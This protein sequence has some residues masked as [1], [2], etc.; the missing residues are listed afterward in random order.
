MNNKNYSSISLRS[1]VMAKSKEGIN[2]SKKDSKKPFISENQEVSD[3]SFITPNVV[4][5]LA[6]EVKSINES[7]SI[8]VPLVVMS[9]GK[10][11][12]EETVIAE[13]KA[14]KKVLKVGSYENVGIEIQGDLMESIKS[15]NRS[16]SL[17]HGNDDESNR[18]KSLTDYHRFEEKP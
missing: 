14:P 12:K 15:Y 18:W 10:T 4:K 11:K 13:T 6:I 5:D 2:E 9:E 7:I 8:K 1:Y 17:T 16:K 3:E